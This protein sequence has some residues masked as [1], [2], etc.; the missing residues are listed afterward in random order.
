M[1]SAKR[2]RCK[3]KAIMNAC[4]LKIGVADQN[5]KSNLISSLATL[6]L[7]ILCSNTVRAAVITWTNPNSGN[8][9]VATNW[10]PS[11]VPG[12]T[13]IASITPT[14]NLQV[15]LDANVIVAGLSL[16]TATLYPSSYSLTVNGAFVWSGGTI[17][18]N[19]GGNLTLNGASSFNGVG[20]HS[21]V[22]FYGQ[23][24]NSGALTWSGSGTNLYFGDSTI[25]NL[26]SG[27]ITIASDV[28]CDT[29]SGNSGVIGNAG[30]VTKTGGT[31][32]TALNAT[33][34]NSSNATV[35]VQSGTLS[36]NGAYSYGG[37]TEAGQVTI[38]EGTA[39]NFGGVYTHS[40]V[41]G[42][43]ETGPGTLTIS[44]GVVNFNNPAG[45]T[46]SNLTV[47]GGTLGGTG[48]LLAVD[49]QF[50]WSG[51]NI[52]N[53]GGSLTLNGTSSFNGVGYH[54]MV[55]N[56]HLINV[57]TLTWSGSGT[58]LLFY[59]GT[60]S[61][62]AA[63]TIAI[64]ADVSCDDQINIATI[65][66]AGLVT[67][68][69]TTGTTTLASTFVNTGTLNVQG[70]II[71]LAGSY[72][73]NNGTL[74]FGISGTTN[75]G[76]INLSGAASF[77]GGIGVNLN[78]FYWPTV[79]SSF[80]LLTYTSESGVL[81]TNTALPPFIT[82]QTN[83]NPTVF[84]LSVVARQTNT[85]PTNLTMSLAGN[86][87]LNLAWPGDHTGWQLETQT[88]SLQVGLSTNWVIVPGSGLTNEMTF[89]IVLA[90]GSVFYRLMYP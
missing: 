86:T 28:S 18:N 88:N 40:V 9:S 12:S 16:S 66:N 79:G 61:N 38:A 60:I 5:T 63:S 77:K 3:Q 29:G 27:T 14:N 21:M 44:G 68:T 26:A 7:M 72:N 25:T 85:A 75:Y 87:S 65:N 53:Y 24:I 58:N 15:T 64:A 70:G 39:L 2:N 35:V 57:G 34:V 36:L 50:T 55:F 59:G 45:N 46:V 6:L 23:I 89:P 10:S 48:L 80:N 19:G 41:D 1:V 62:L 67:K 37:G 84:T 22:L 76:S 32:T 13:D 54:V 17:N 20:Y 73:L 42:F 31:G 4:A 47:I 81:F 30:L 90:N 82:W 74:D 51:G 83:Y 33:F 43:S 52:G 11:L 49:G 71:N 78:G 69:G 56:S 8:W